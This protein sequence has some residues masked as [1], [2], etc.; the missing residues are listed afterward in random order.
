MILPVKELKKESWSVGWSGGKDSTATIIKMHE[1]GVPI[2]NISYVEMMYN[3]DIPATLPIM[4]DFVRSASDVFRSWGYDVS[5]IRPRK[6][7]VDLMNA[8]YRR[9][10]RAG[11]NG[12][13]YG[14][15]VLCRGACGLQKYKEQALSFIHTSDYHMV[16]YAADEISRIHRLTEKKQSILCSLGIT[17]SKTYDI[18]RKYDL[19]SPLYDTGITRDGCFF[20]PNASVLERDYLYRNYSDLAQLIFDDI[21][22]TPARCYLFCRNLNNFIRDYELFDGAVPSCLIPS[23][24]V[25]VSDDEQVRFPFYFV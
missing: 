9:S 7:L 12:Q 6:T 2:S 20:C 16:G 13:K 22:G 15:G 14:I 21:S 8:V 3:N 4:H 24:T 18:C 5:I 25:F 19:L 23:S 17:E 1:C 11:A 10:K